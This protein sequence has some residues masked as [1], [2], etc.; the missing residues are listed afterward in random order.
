VIRNFSFQA[1]TEGVGNFP[2]IRKSLKINARFLR[3]VLQ[4]YR[5]SVTVG[6]GN[7]SSATK[8]AFPVL[9]MSATLST[10]ALALVAV[11]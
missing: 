2:S 1:S 11:R 8:F 5:T 7:F 6:K 3:D 10:D 9:K 4:D